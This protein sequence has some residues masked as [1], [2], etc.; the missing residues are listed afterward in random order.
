MQVIK[1]AVFHNQVAFC[2]SVTL[3]EKSID[4]VVKVDGYTN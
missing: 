2:D 1:V 3:Q 4:R